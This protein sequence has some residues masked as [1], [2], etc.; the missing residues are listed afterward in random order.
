M[1]ISVNHDVNQKFIIIMF[2]PLDLF[3]GD[4]CK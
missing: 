3:C 4:S 1:I 2:L